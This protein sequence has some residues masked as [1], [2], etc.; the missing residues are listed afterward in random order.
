MKKDIFSHHSELAVSSI[1]VRSKIRK[2]EAIQSSALRKIN[3]TQLST[4]G[5]CTYKF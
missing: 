5:K 2:V 4:K 1:L 3:K